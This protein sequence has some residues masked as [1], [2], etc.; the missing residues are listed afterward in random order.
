MKS[1]KRNLYVAINIAD[2]MPV[3]N[4]YV[5]ASHIT[6]NSYVSHHSALSYYGYTNQVYYDVFVSS[7][8]KFN[9]F[10]FNGYSYRYIKSRINEGIIKN[11]DE[12]VITDLERTI[13][14]CINDFDKVGGLEELLLSLSM[15]PYADEEKMIYYL[16]C[17][18]KQILYQKTG[19]LLE[20]FK[21]DLG[22]SY[23]FF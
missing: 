12:S 19:Y 4:Q 21:T 20:Y 22:F 23:I 5:I 6:E 3:V 1:V 17:Y 9:P 8:L 10:E 11:G 13:I 16:D 7:V 18:D 14:D 15:I 2:G